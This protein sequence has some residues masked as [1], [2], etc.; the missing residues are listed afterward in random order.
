MIDVNKTLTGNDAFTKIDNIVVS[1]YPMLEGFTVEAAGLYAFFRAWKYNKEGAPLHNCVWLSRKEIQELT[2]LKR[3]K[4]EKYL[5][6][7][8]KY[9]LIE[10]TKAQRMFTTPN[11]DIFVVKSPLTEAEF[12]VKY[13]K[14]VAAFSENMAVINRVN[15]EHREQFQQKRDDWKARQIKKLD[16]DSLSHKIVQKSESDTGNGDES[17]LDGEV[18]YTPDGQPFQF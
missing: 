9:E 1:M 11:K 12:R 17:G 3:T 16:G 13:A 15:Q 10:V 6:V 4:F 18:Y 2:G 14:E 8:V 7:L 5:D